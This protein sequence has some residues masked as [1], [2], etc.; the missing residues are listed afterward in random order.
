MA[1]KL[2]PLR[3][4]RAAGDISLAIVNIVFLLIF[5]FM[6][7]GQETVTQGN[8]RLPRT[9]QLTGAQIPSNVLVVQSA[10][11]WLLGGAPI[12]PEL[13]GSALGPAG[14]TVYLMLDRDAPAELLLQTL[15][16]PELAGYD[17]RLVSL[18][19]GGAG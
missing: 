10:D 1:L 5:F 18:R 3:K 7:I 8:V 12:S 4:R 17:I 13:L 16:R 11:E 2:P 9:D 19:E 6:L 14:E 15:A